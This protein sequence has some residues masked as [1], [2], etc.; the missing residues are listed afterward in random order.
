MAPLQKYLCA[1]GNFGNVYIGQLR[2]K[3][4]IFKTVAIKILKG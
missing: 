2:M 3:G 4:D 1:L